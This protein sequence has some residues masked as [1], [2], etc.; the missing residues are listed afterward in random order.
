MQ[1]I[2]IFS[3]VDFLSLDEGVKKVIFHLCNCLKTHFHYQK[4]LIKTTKSNK[5]LFSWKLCLFFKCNFYD[6]ILYIPESSCTFN[7]F[8]RAKILKI[9]SKKSKVIILGLQKRKINPFLRLFLPLLKPDCFFVSSKESGRIF[10]KVFNVKYF[11]P[12]VDLK[13][14]FPV[15]K[16]VKIKLREKYGIPQDKFISLHVG[17]IKK[18]RNLLLLTE[19]LDK[20]EDFLLIVG[21][22]STKK[23][24]DVYQ[25]LER[26][27][28][29]RVITHYIEKI[30]EIY[31]LADC[32]L[33]PV[34]DYKSAI[35]VP[36][37]VL[38]AMACNLPVITTEFG[39]LVDLFKEDSQK[40]FF[41][42]DSE[43]ELKEK[44]KL[45][46][47]ISRPDTKG[48][49]KDLSWEKVIE[50]FIGVDGNLFFLNH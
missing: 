1:K 43:E 32:Y 23:E 41:Y 36:L 42:F 27:E 47:N 24:Q 44:I 21:S 22:T 2:V 33:F 35:D 30:E 16:E 19:V 3:E 20:K 50:K 15:E 8:I 34:K 7:S 11:Y 49:V 45:V 12:G 6:L 29:V 37:S 18:K 46:K 17:H 38:E 13:K 25:K 5:L 28:N 4:N 10:E 39:G 26:K 48:M 9:Y 31:R 40:G 14:F